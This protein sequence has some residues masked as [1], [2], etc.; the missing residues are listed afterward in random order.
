MDHLECALTRFFEKGKEVFS[1]KDKRK[2]DQKL[3]I[4]ILSNDPISLFWISQNN[5]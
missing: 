5:F 2:T 3:I 1:E 4:V